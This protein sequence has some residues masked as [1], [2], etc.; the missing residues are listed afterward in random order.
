MA[1]EAAITRLF[2]G[3]KNVTKTL[4]DMPD[5]VREQPP[6]LDVEIKDFDSIAKL[7]WNI[8]YIGRTNKIFVPAMIS[9][10]SELA[11]H[12]P[13]KKIHFMVIGHGYDR[14]ELMKKEFSGL[15]NIKLTLFGVMSPIPRILFS[16]IDV[17]LAGAQSAVFAADE[18]VLTITAD[19]ETDR[20]PGVL[21]Y[22]TQDAWYGS[23]EKSFSYFE[24]LE[25]V[26]VKR[27]YDNK[28]YD[29]PELKPVDYYYDNFWTIVKNADK[30]KEYYN[31]P[32]SQDRTRN[33]VAIFPFGIIPKGAR[34]ILCG[35][36][37][38][39]KDY[40]K[41][42]EGQQYGQII[43]TVDEHDEEFDN[44]VQSLERLRNIDYDCIVISTFPQNA[45]ETYNKIL[46]VV[47]QMQGRIIY[48]FQIGNT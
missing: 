22:D 46:Q 16:K 12:Y 27:L 14:L 30:K 19:A 42:V 45:Q 28:I 34:I 10:I 37:E 1:S 8:C 15:T 6:I 48:N 5:T 36:T 11:K 35:A 20:T 7:D 47:P 43:T 13:D 17:V 23:K 9:G 31:E 40:I 4:V 33:W 32:L 41:Q 21:G 2:N 25:N 39:R 44:S 24:V 29:M 26:L 38:I 3:Y 18:G